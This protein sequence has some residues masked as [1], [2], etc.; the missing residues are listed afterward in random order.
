MTVTSIEAIVRKL[1]DAGVPFLVVGGLA[2]VAHGYGRLTQDVDLVIQLDP[3]TIHRAFDALAA[4]GYRPI[5]QVDS[6]AFADAEQ[7]RRLIDE[8]GLTVLN[9]WSDT[10]R[11]TP[12]DVF[13]SEPFDFEYEYRNA[14]V[15]EIAD[16]VP[17]R[18]LRLSAL[19]EMK[20]TAGRLQDLADIEELRLLHGSEET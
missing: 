3:V 16:G 18:V 14:M 15:Q 1:N 20:K 19:I 5:V 8:K 9:F 11:D 2:V 12:V 4:I 7:R 6:A 13:V 17:I 10:H